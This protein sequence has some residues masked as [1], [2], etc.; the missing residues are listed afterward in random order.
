MIADFK[1]L[2]ILLFLFFGVLFLI[3]MNLQAYQLTILN[4]LTKFKYPEIRRKIILID[5]GIHGLFIPRPINLMRLIWS[6]KGY[7]SELTKIILGVRKYQKLALLFFLLALSVPFLIENLTYKDL[8][9]KYCEKD[10][11]CKGAFGIC[12]SDYKTEEECK[13]NG[14]NWHIFVSCLAEGCPEPEKPCC[15]LPVKCI[16]NYCKLAIGE[17]SR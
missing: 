10:E 12:N 16:G 13:L 14:G 2:E 8:E 4:K 15:E 6:D 11:D 1:S 17:V 7:S 9:K 3:F 5:L